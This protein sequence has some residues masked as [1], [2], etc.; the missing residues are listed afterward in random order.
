M[1]MLILFYLCSVCLL[2]IFGN[3][4]VLYYPVTPFQFKSE[5][6]T[7]MYKNTE[8]IQLILILLGK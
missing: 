8:T 6:V 1:C 7:D 2:G 5:E 3:L 4:T